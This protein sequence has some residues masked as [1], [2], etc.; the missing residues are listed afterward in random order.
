VTGSAIAIPL[1]G[2]T[3]AGAA[4]GTAWDRVAECETGGFW[5]QNTGNG[6]YGGLQLTQEDW[7]VYGGLD[8]ASSAD[9][10]SRSQQIAV[11]ERI[12]ADKSAD[13]WPTCGLLAGL[14]GDTADPGVDAGASG[15]T[16]SGETPENSGSS[17]LFDS[18][19]GSSAS[20][21]A[22]PSPSA[23]PGEATAD[24]LSSTG[25]TDESGDSGMSGNAGASSA[26]GESGE[27]ADSGDSIEWDDSD[28]S[29]QS[30]GLS[31]DAETGGTGTGRHRGPSAGEAAGGGREGGSAGRHASRD[32]DARDVGDGTYSVRAGDSLW[33]I[34]DSLD[35][36]GGW[37]ELYVANEEAIGGD[38]DLILPGQKL[39]V[40]GETVEK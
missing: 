19:D 39:A 9:R 34:A 22:S 26:S 38:P 13:A 17:G 11:A 14:D 35:L 27:S 32:A 23:S 7:E 40:Q 28:K 21:S 37:R 25:T 6:Y 4:D 36:R 16:D 18:L 3:G 30:G 15:L 31:E 12:L 33:G 1:L 8:F 2:A 24:P 20:G 10:A 29:G 5:S